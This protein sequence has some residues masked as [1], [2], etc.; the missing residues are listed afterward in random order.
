MAVNK[1]FRCK[2]DIA[3]GTECWDKVHGKGRRKVP[4]CQP[5]DI[6]AAAGYARGRQGVR[7]MYTSSKAG[8]KP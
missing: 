4:L 5:C 7:N 6:L 1:C 8:G 2:K 3:A